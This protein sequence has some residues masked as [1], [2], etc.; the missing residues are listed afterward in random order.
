MRSP[1]TT[2]AFWRWTAAAEKLGVKIDRI[3]FKCL[4]GDGDDRRA[5]GALSQALHLY[6]PFRRGGAGRHGQFYKM[7][8]ERILV[9]YDDI[10]LDVGRRCA[11]AARAR[12]GGHNGI[13]NIIYLHRHAT[14]FP[15]S[16]SAWGKAASRLR[17][18]RLGAQP[19]HRRGAR[20]AWNAVLD[21]TPDTARADCGRQRSTKR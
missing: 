1:G 2:R 12:D 8:S 11:S 14:H 13:K 7:P 17:P 18:G 9:L 16:R 3:K 15:G 5:P 6:E 4:C 20:S 21:H 19:F 10:S